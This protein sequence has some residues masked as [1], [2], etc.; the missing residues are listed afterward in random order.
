MPFGSVADSAIA[1]R[2]A[3]LTI[4]VLRAARMDKR[5]L[6]ELQRLYDQGILHNMS[7]VLNGASESAHGYG[8]GYG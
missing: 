8:Y 5:A 2:I 1:N 3:D 4:F 7:I 6:P